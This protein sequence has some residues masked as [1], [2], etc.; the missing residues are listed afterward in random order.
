MTTIAGKQ[1]RII[2]VGF[3][4]FR[5]W[6]TEGGSIDRCLGEVKF[7]LID[8]EVI[9]YCPRIIEDVIDFNQTSKKVL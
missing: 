2:Q 9:V 7:E 1:L 3:N 4:V 5:L 8:D 6:I